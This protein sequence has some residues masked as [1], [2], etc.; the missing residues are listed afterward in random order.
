MLPFFD[1]K[2]NRN[3][4]ASLPPQWNDDFLIVTTQNDA[5]VFN[6]LEDDLI[7]LRAQNQCELLTLL[8]DLAIY[9]GKMRCLIEGDGTDD[10]GAR[11]NI[12][13]LIGAAATGEVRRWFPTDGPEWI[14]GV[15]IHPERGFIFQ[16][17]LRVLV[18]TNGDRDQDRDEDK[19]K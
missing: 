10:E 12:A 3:V 13:R 7:S 19:R 5:T 8:H 1:K 15:G 4:E 9:D 18:R 2:I 6:F 11:W 14:P 17:D 16:F